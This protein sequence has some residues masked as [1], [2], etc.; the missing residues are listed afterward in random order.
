MKQHFTLIREMDARTLRY[1]F[2]KLENIENIDPEQLAE[3]VKAPKQ[4]KR[5]LSLSKE[6]EKIIEKFGR[7]TNLLVNYIIMTESTA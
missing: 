4:H 7:A 1:Y 3:V 5:P 2:H 6:E